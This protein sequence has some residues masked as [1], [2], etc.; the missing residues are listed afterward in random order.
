MHASGISSIRCRTIDLLALLLGM[1]DPSSSYGIYNVE[2]SQLV[3]SGRLFEVSEDFLNQNRLG[4]QGGG[5]QVDISSG[6]HNDK[7]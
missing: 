4:L 7:R 3:C 2:Y 1:V 6:H 5:E